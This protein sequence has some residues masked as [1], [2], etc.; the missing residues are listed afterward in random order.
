MY[1]RQVFNGV[2]TKILAVDGFTDIINNFITDN[3]MTRVRQVTEN[4][5]SIVDFL[6]ALSPSQWESLQNI[7]QFSGFSDQ[8]SK[9][10][11]E[12]QKMQ[13]F[14]VDVYK[15]QSHMFSI[16]FGSNRKI[17]CA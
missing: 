7:S 12:I 16:W 14:G 5:D 8:I 4:A 17:W 10:A 6:Y 2:C 11:S 13:T 9:T 1:K 3:K 15:R